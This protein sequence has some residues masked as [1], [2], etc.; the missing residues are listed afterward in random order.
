MQHLKSST[1]AQHNDIEHA[2]K[3]LR[4]DYTHSEYRH[5]LERM[6]G[7]Y[8][9]WEREVQQQCAIQDIEIY[10]D[11]WK[12]PLLKQDL[13]RL[14]LDAEKIEAVENPCEVPDLGS[15]SRLLGSMYV[16]EGSTLGGKMLAMHFEN[17]LGITPDKGGA[18]FA[19]YG[20]QA[21]ARW[22]AFC[23][24]MEQESAGLD[25]NETADSARDTFHCMN[26]WLSDK[27]SE[28]VAA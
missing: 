18:F 4:L 3:L 8:R 2:L 14:G 19:S 10:Y 17:L 22:R 27:H 15:K 24:F 6:Y 7:F 23:N 25:Y 20:K 11:R 12:A 13:A 21:A 26:H 1:A 5:L 28:R 16:I 9:V